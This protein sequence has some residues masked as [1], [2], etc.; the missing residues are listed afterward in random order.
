MTQPRE[1]TVLRD[2]A[3]RLAEVF[4]AAA[5][6][7]GKAED[8]TRLRDAETARVAAVLGRVDAAARRRVMSARRAATAAEVQAAQALADEMRYQA[9]S[10]ALA[11]VH[12]YAGMLADEAEVANLKGREKLARFGEVISHL[13]TASA[14]ALLEVIEKAEAGRLA[15]AQ[16]QVADLSAQIRSALATL[17]APP[18]EFESGLPRSRKARRKARQAAQPAG[19]QESNAEQ[20]DV[21]ELDPKRRR[22]AT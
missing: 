6:L 15:S 10:R 12:R 13:D 2:I 19:A 4:E 20:A 5:T 21:V 9:G 3:R 1:G 16:R 22:T 7:V 14:R 18:V 11:A 17:P 8:E